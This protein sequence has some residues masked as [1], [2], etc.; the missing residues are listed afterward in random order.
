MTHPS[1]PVPLFTDHPLLDQQGTKVGAVVDV[2]SDSATLEPRYFVVD[3]GAFRATHYVPVLGSYQ[4]ARGDIVVPYDADAVKHAPK[5]H[6]DH[7]VTPAV[8]QQI[9]EHYG[10]AS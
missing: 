10:L 4:T 6:R 3:P 7:I 1:Q 2:V 9:I 8:E 5:A